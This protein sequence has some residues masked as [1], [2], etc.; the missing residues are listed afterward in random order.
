MRGSRALGPPADPP[1]YHALS[2]FML[3]EAIAQL[4]PEAS[5]RRPARAAPRALDTLA[6]LVAPDGDMSYLGRGQ[7]QTWVPALIAGGAGRAARATSPAGSRAAPRA[8]SPS[9]G[10]RCTGS[11]APREHAPGSS[12]S[13]AATRTTADGID[14]Y[15]HT[16]AYNGLALFGLTAALD[17]LDAIPGRPVGRL[18]ADRRLAVARPRRERARRRRGRPRLARR[19]PE[20][21]QPSATC[22]TTSARSRSSAATAA[23]LDGPARAAAADAAVTAE[24]GGPALIR[25]GRRRSRRRASAS[26][27]AAAIKVAAGY[28]PASAG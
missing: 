16:V 5:P 13:P 28:K 10:A 23:R 12:S 3:T 14:G 27:C 8:T 17:A 26:T 2:T 1:A 21:M 7:G 4:G 22:A 15:A 20:P 25:D 24:H 19:A 11:A 6:A 9:P 18:P